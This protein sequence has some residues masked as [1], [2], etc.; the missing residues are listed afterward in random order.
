MLAAVDVFL[1]A[2]TILR[3]KDQLKEAE[4]LDACRRVVGV[5][6]HGLARHQPCD[7]GF[8]KSLVALAE[9]EVLILN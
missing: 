1:A 6:N 5:I 2:S 8:T 3:A 9:K 4:L 7:D